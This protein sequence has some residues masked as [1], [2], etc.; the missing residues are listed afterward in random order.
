MLVRPAGSPD[1][2]QL[3]DEEYRRASGSDD[4]DMVDIGCSIRCICGCATVQHSPH[5]PTAVL[6]HTL[7]RQLGAMLDICTV[8]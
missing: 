5:H 1:M 7:W 8:S 4:A 6:L 2:A 3:S